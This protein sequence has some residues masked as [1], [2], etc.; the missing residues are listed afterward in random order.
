MRVAYAFVPSGRQACKR[1]R[2]DGRGNYYVGQDAAFF[3][4]DVYKTPVV[5]TRVGD[6]PS[7]IVLADPK[8]FQSRPRLGPS[9]CLGGGLISQTPTFSCASE[10]ARKLSEAAQLARSWMQISGARGVPIAIR[11]RRWQLAT[12]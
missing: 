10:Y 5:A 7:G 4:G 12:G 8:L 11:R 3:Q 9:S 6:A 2:V 1:F